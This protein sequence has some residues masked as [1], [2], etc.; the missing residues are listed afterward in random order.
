MHANLRTAAITV[1]LA[2]AAVATAAGSD[3]CAEARR[4]LRHAEYL[5]HC[6]VSAR[7]LGPLGTP[8][9]AAAR[10]Y[11]QAALAFQAVA[12][13]EPERAEAWVGLADARRALGQYDAARAAL[14]TLRRL[15]ARRADELT[16]SL[17]RYLERLAA[18]PSADGC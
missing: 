2:L 11:E 17:D 7:G 8:P 18:G 12:A 15:D 6:E 13:A 10:E 3:P 16:E 5:T 14:D 4:L 1:T 9:G